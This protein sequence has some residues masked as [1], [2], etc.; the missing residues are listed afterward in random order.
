MATKKTIESLSFPN[1]TVT[2]GDVFAA[3][4]GYEQTN[5]TFYQVEALKGKSTAV[6]REIRAEVVYRDNHMSGEKKPRLNEFVNEERLTRRIVSKYREI[7]VKIFDF[8]D[9]Y[10]TSPEETHSFSSYA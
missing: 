2:I 10:L 1:G 8:S 6:L 7:Q 3:S 4:W 5:V 9:A